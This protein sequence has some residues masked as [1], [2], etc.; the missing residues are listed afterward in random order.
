MN[1][2]LEVFELLVSGEALLLGHAAV[3]GDGREVLLCQQ[4]GQGDAPL[5]RLDEDDN[6]KEKVRLG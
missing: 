3:D 4:L 1:Y 5:H 6:L 2:L